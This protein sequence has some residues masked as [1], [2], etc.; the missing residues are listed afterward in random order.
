MRMRG[1]Q[2]VRGLQFLQKLPLGTSNEAVSATA[3]HAKVSPPIVLCLFL[4]GVLTCPETLGDPLEISGLSITRSGAAEP[5]A[6]ASALRL[7]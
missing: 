6:D 4:V 5:S 7:A 1:L 3:N 2:L